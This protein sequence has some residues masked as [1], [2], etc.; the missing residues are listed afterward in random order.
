V[1]G[2]CF[3]VFGFFSALSDDQFV[4]SDDFDRFVYESDS[5]IRPSLTNGFTP[6]VITSDAD[7]I[8]LGL[9]GTGHPKDPFVIENNWANIS[10]VTFI[11]ISD[12]SKHFIIR[13]NQF[14]SASTLSGIGIYLSNVTNGLITDNT[15]EHM[16]YGIQVDDFSSFNLIRN[17]VIT[18]VDT[19]I[20][21]HEGSYFN[22]LFNNSISNIDFIG[23]WT[24][25]PVSSGIHP[26][27]NVYQEN[28]ITNAP[29][30]GIGEWL[31]NDSRYIDN[32]VSNSGKG[33]TLSS[34]INAEVTGNHLH[35]N[36]YGI[37]VE[38]WSG[39]RMSDSAIFT[40]NR[41]FDN[42]FGIY[43][44]EG[45]NNVFDTNLI[46]NSTQYGFY[47]LSKERVS[48]IIINND[49]IDNN[50]PG[51]SQA[52]DDHSVNLYNN[53]YWSDHTNVDVDPADGFADTEYY[54][55]S[56]FELNDPFPVVSP[57]FILHTFSG[58]EII[59]PNG[60]E[61]LRGI[62]E[63]IWTAGSD[64]S[65]QLFYTLSYSPD[66]GVNWFDLVI[67]ST[68]TS[69]IWDT[70]TVDD[71][72][73]YLVRVFTDNKHG[74]TFTNESDGT[75]TIQNVFLDP[76]FINGDEAFSVLAEEL[77]LPGDGSS[78]DPYI[79][80]NYVFR[81]SDSALFEVHH[82]TVYFIVKNNQLD[83][84]SGLYDGIVL[85]NVINAVFDNNSVTRSLNGFNLTDS[86]DITITDNDIFAN[87]ANGILATNCNDLTINNNKV[88]N[89]GLDGIN[90]VNTH[91]SLIQGNQIFGNG[92]GSGFSEEVRLSISGI[93]SI[94]GLKAFFGSGIFLDPSNHNT[95]DQNNILGNSISGVQLMDSNFTT[96][97]SNDINGNGAYGIAVVNSSHGVF[98]D[99]DVLGNGYASADLG[100]NYATFSRLSV[101]GT[102]GLNAFFGSGIFLDPSSNNTVSNSNIDGNAD[103]GVFLS[104][105][106]DTVVTGNNITDNGI[107]GIWVEESNDFEITGNTIGGNGELATLGLASANGLNAFFGSG[108]FLDPSDGGLVS[109]NTIFDNTNNGLHLFQTSHI[110]IE[111]NNIGSNDVHGVFLE[112]SSSNTVFNNTIHENGLIQNTGASTAGIDSPLG[113]KAF[114]GSGIFLDP[115]DDNNV[116]ENTV[117]GNSQHGIHLQE[118]D[119]SFVNGNTVSGNNEHGVFLEDSSH[120]TVKGNTITSNGQFIAVS[121]A[122]GLNAFFGSGIFLDPA[123]DNVVEGNVVNNNAE[124]GIHLEL[125]DNSQILGNNVSDN[126]INGIFLEGSSDNLLKQ[127]RV[128]GNGNSAGVASIS[129]L[130][131]FFGSGIFLDPGSNNTVED[132]YVSDNAF[133]GVSLLEMDDSK[134]LDNEIVN[135]GVVGLSLQNSSSNLIQGND[136]GNNSQQPQLASASG[137]NAFF[138]SGIFLDPSFYNIFS[139]N[140]IFN[141]LFGIQVEASSGNS[142]FG[143]IIKDNFEYGL[144]FDFFSSGN[145]AS[146]NDFINNNEGDTQ[147]YDDGGNDF[148]T[149]FWSDLEDP[150]EPYII[151]GGAGSTDE[152]PSPEPSNFEAPFTGIPYVIKPN[153]K[154]HLRG[155]V[156]VKWTLVDPEPDVVVTYYVFYGE[157]VEVEDPVGHE[158]YEE[159]TVNEWVLI[160]SVEDHNI[161]WWDTT[162]VDNGKYLIKVIAEAD[163]YERFDSSDRFFH[164]RN[165][166]NT[167]P[168]VPTSPGFE[169]LGILGL[170]LVGYLYKKKK[171]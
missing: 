6:I 92:F 16:M 43:L 68:T 116:T 110:D 106:E 113:L 32:V 135:N 35:D 19:G 31:T 99:N 117:F 30:W 163:G 48:N 97:S 170:V 133:F 115:S 36:T 3:S 96:V 21:V 149:N 103:N 146:N 127:N 67:D 63:V 55:N 119:D 13:N 72:N 90:F 51:S 114:F 86:S 5:I 125:T 17:N 123:T 147:A 15:F 23:I 45:T 154:E 57:H 20:Y 1:L 33:L 83:G 162:T 84:L 25:S 91:D 80:E 58:A 101:S 150:T 7:F 39:E 139:D 102:D 28:V 76:V 22:T 151:A 171:F 122:T 47:S 168:T 159:N 64:S 53:S 95:I 11:S 124:N 71:G 112:N 104:V 62:T 50:L 88:Y 165:K 98:D 18:K 136:I 141:N 34:S 128:T 14:F 44:R 69:Y 87:D 77:G 54:I 27:N 4:F 109:G 156:K 111:N 79:F 144:F 66:G 74:D 65:Y 131:A 93:S 2:F 100:D 105:T 10:G 37:W 70:N 41:L 73:N 143:N 129:G 130:N 108:I 59:Q 49:F 152:T 8:S 56:P 12:T 38:Q 24:T 78:E 89:N 60:G 137:L 167:K 138:G 85:N 118:T 140:N 40:Q 107:G 161:L 29:Q 81:S 82:T 42:T 121:S 160:D 132:N 134:I 157:L 155:T 46:V 164:V 26:H 94:K 145:D 126:G 120:N 52:Y 9:P 166:K 142:F 61:T 148:S 158:W 153:G 169:L 75:F